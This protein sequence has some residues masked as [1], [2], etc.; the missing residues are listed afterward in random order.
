MPNGHNLTDTRCRDLDAHL[1]Q[2]TLDAS[3]APE[4][5][6]AIGRNRCSTVNKMRSSGG[7]STL[8]PSRMT[9]RRHRRPARWATLVRMPP[10][11]NRRPGSTAPARWSRVA[12][13]VGA[14]ESIPPSGRRGRRRWQM[15]RRR[16]RSWQRPGGQS[17][18]SRRGRSWA[19]TN[20]LPRSWSREQCG[21]EVA[22]DGRSSTFN[23]RS[24][25]ELEGRAH[26]ASSSAGLHFRRRQHRL[27]LGYR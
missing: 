7:P 9:R 26:G 2:F 11:E 23:R 17:M 20:R 3:L 12:A 13:T 8:S 1:E 16:P 10:S 18:A 27:R 5:R 25:S 6:S 15:E 19:R 4:G 24:R 22:V 14:R 21:R